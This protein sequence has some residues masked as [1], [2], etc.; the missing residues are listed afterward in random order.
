MATDDDLSKMLEN[1]RA[2][3]KA[4]KTKQRDAG[5]KAGVTRKQN[6]AAKEVALKKKQEEE[7]EKERQREEAV[8]KRKIAAGMEN[9]EDKKIKMG[10][11]FLMLIHK[12]NM[13][14]LIGLFMNWKLEKY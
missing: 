5:K 3:L 8:M 14:K 4:K 1:Y 13:K 9:P 2:G 7:K 6:K 11:G 12:E 10:M